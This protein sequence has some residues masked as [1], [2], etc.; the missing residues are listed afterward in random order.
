MHGEGHVLPTQFMCSRAF[1]N[2][3]SLKTTVT[4][5]QGLG[6]TGAESDALQQPKK[7]PKASKKALLPWILPPSTQGPRS[8]YCGTHKE[9]RTTSQVAR[10]WSQL[11]DLCLVI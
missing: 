8:G 5:H 1:W 9:Q 7:Q 11:C 2:T 6:L 10:L 4:E 3:H